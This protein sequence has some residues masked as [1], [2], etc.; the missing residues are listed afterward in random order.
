MCCFNYVY[1]NDQ[2]YRYELKLSLE[3]V[4][5]QISPSAG[6]GQIIDRKD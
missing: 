3:E 2:M 6:Y 5:C 4:N 1:N